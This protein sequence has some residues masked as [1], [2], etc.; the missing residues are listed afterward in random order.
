MPFVNQL[1]QLVVKKKQGSEQKK[2]KHLGMPGKRRLEPRSPSEGRR[3]SKRDPSSLPQL[4]SIPPGR[5]GRKREP[6][7]QPRNTSG[8]CE[9]KQKEGEVKMDEKR[10]Y[11]AV[12]IEEVQVTAEWGEMKHQTEFPA[13]QPYIRYKCKTPDT[14]G[15]ICPLTGKPL[16]DPVLLGDGFAYERKSI[17]QWMEK[18]PVAQRAPSGLKLKT[19]AYAE[20]MALEGLIKRCYSFPPRCRVR[21]SIFQLPV[22]VLPILDEWTLCGFGS[23]MDMAVWMQLISA[24]WANHLSSYF[25]EAKGNDLEKTHCVVVNRVLYPYSNAYQRNPMQVFIPKLP[26]RKAEPPQFDETKNLKEIESLDN[27]PSAGGIECG[28]TILRDLCADGLSLRCESYFKGHAFINCLFTKC[29]FSAP[30]FHNYFVACKFVDCTF[31][32]CRANTIDTQDPNSRRLFFNCRLSDCTTIDT[33]GEPSGG[34]SFAKTLIGHQTDP[35]YASENER[36]IKAHALTP[37]EQQ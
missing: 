21:G 3:R 1:D 35:D 11:L 10:A 33:I 17:V 24:T 14:S 16:H 20:D 31:M 9:K 15:W 30:I 5:R 28:R 18:N 7:R 22:Q 13:P 32:E 19:K 27:I 4:A 26:Q 8:G 23:T 6:P 12:E 36:Q 25:R 37:L 29:S 2:N 34:K